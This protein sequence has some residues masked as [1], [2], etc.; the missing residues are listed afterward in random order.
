MLEIGLSSLMIAIW[1]FWI[2]TK[3]LY[4]L[5]ELG[6][7]RV[8]ALVLAVLAVISSISL[9]I[10]SINI[11]NK[12]RMYLHLCQCMAG[13]LAYYGTIKLVSK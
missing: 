9:Q 7:M 1:P 11:D 12:E 10:A 8:T 4:D 3:C 6:W 5:S 13:Y 2:L